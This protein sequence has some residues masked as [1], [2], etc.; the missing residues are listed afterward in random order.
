MHRNKAGIVAE[1]GEIGEV[2][3]YP[4]ETLPKFFTRIKNTMNQI[5]SE[6]DY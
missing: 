1:L 5:A 4:N 6:S 2:K 3:N